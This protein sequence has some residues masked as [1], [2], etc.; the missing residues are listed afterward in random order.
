MQLATGQSERELKKCI[1]MGI[2]TFQ[3]FH[4]GRY[5]VKYKVGNHVLWVSVSASP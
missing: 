2:T 4:L 1:R 5:I 3:K